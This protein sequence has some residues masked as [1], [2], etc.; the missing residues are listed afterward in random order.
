[1][2]DVLNDTEKV[3]ML[4][5][6]VCGDDISNEARAKIDELQRKIEVLKQKTQRAGKI[7][8]S[9]V[10]AIGKLSQRLNEVIDAVRHHKDVK[11][12]NRCWLDDSVL[13]HKVLL[14]EL[15]ALNHD[16]MPSKEDFLV[17]CSKFY[18]RRLPYHN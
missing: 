4:R 9:H 16:S 13:Y 8:G 11:G 3:S 7:I 2:D 18:D 5:C 15:M 10:V 14:D 17:R 1:M 6:V 12:G